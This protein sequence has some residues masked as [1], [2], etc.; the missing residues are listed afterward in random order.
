[1]VLKAKRAG[2][3]SS[4]VDPIVTEESFEAG[5]KRFNVTRAVTLPVWKFEENET[6][7]FRILDKITESARF[8]D[9]EIKRAKSDQMPP[10]KVAH[11]FDLIGGASYTL[12]F[13]AG[14]YRDLTENYPDDA[15]VGKAFR[16]TKLKSRK[17]KKGYNFNP[18]SVAEIEES[19]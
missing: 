6:K 16:V 13:G 18:Y 15:Y 8:S 17:T 9:D 4:E 19:A 7:C 3:V 14:L 11:V 5:G 12:I 10:A 2:R 1:M